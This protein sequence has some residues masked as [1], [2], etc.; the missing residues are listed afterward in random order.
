MKLQR[1][2]SWKKFAVVAAAIALTGTMMPGF[3]ANRGGKS[4]HQVRVERSGQRGPGHQSR[5]EKNN[6]RKPGHQV[7]VERSGQRGPAPQIR[8]HN[9]PVPQRHPHYSYRDGRYYRGGPLGRVVIPA[10]FGRI[11]ISLPGVYR[12]IHVGPRFYYHCNGV[13]YIRHAH[14]Y[15]VVRAP[16][17]RFLPYHARRIVI[18]GDVFFFHNNVYYCYRD[19]FY[20]VCEP[21]VVVES[22]DVG[23]TTVMVE[24]SNGSRT[25]IELEPLGS[26]QWKGPRGEVYDGLPSNEQ[27]KEGYGF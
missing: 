21:P 26:N 11:V 23:T 22:K 10:P 20:E 14:G 7:R 2:T 27:L 18:G 8:Q 5:V 4:R 9:H 17:I 3:S 13:Y 19:G 6:Q 24:N 1:A 15:E 16:R 12:T 25:P